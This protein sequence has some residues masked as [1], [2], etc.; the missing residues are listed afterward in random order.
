MQRSRFWRFPA[1]LVVVAMLLAACGSDAEEGPAAGGGGGDEPLKT[2]KIG[3]IAPLS[4]SL[5]ALGSGIRNSVELAIRQANEENKVKGW[6][7]ELAAE[8]DTAKAEVGAQVATKLASDNAVAGVVGTLNSSVALQV[9]PILAR[10][11]IVMVSPAN[12][13]VE[14]TQGT[15]PKNKKRQFDNYFR[16]ATTDNIQGPF[17]ANFATKDLNAKN[18]VTIHDKKTYGQGLVAAFTDQLIKNGGK[19]VAAETI[20]PG[21][22]DFAAVLT[23]IKPLNPDLIYYGGEYPEAQLLTSQAKA[24]GIKA[25]LMGGDGIYDKTYIQT[26]KEAAEGDYCTSV[27]APTEELDSAAE[28]VEAYNAANFKEDFAAYGAYSYDAA[29]VIINAMARVLPEAQAMTPELRKKIVDEV[30]KT[31]FDGVTGKVAFDE[32]GDTTTKVLTVYKVTGQEWKA[33]KTDEFK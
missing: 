22:Q 7:I 14:L 5:S 28:F 4:G 27:G 33:A 6:K 32:F 12:T 29:N 21:D 26:A 19:V 20:N 11:N 16:V 10:E 25:P 30:A 17:A 15:D 24:Q 23:K 3:V 31:N 13:G 9:Q 1:L 18:V 2:V 8:D